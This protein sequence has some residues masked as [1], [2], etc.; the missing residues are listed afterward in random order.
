MQ[1]KTS[2]QLTDD[3]DIA[4][5]G[6]APLVEQAHLLVAEL[7]NELA[8]TKKAR[9]SL[10]RR[11]ATAEVAHVAPVEQLQDAIALLC[12][13][14][15]LDALCAAARAELQLE[16]LRKLAAE[17]PVDQADVE[18]LEDEAE[19]QAWEWV[20]SRKATAWVRKVRV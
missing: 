12:D 10:A 1:S 11:P 9:A 14:G 16:A 7:R 19:H 20:A 13:E 15:I 8:K 18:D 6:L 17:R 3:Q 4:L 2:T 5:A